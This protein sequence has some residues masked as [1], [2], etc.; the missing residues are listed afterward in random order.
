[1]RPALRR[2]PTIMDRYGFGFSLEWED[3]LRGGG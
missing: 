2:V 3:E 1:M